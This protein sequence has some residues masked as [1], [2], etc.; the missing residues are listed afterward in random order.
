MKEVEGQQSRGVDSDLR[1]AGQGWV[2]GW[3]LLMW[4]VF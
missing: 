1:K 2:D 4:R 3:Y